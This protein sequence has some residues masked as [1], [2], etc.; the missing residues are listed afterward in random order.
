MRVYLGS[1]HA[2]FELKNHLVNHL[3]KQGHDVVDVGP[4]VYDPEDDYPAFCLH[5]GA[6]V[7]A[8]PGSLGVVIGGSGNG[9]QIAA[10]KIAGVRVGA[11]LEGRDRRSWPAST[12][13]PTCCGI[14]ARQHTLDEATA[15][16]EA[17]L[18]T[19]FSGNPRHARRIAQ[20]AE[21]ERTRELPP[22][23]ASLIPLSGCGAGPRGAASCAARWS[24][25][26]RRR[27]AAPSVGPG[28]VPGAQ[29][30]PDADLRRAGADQAA[31]PALGLAVVTARARAGGGPGPRRRGVGRGV[32]RRIGSTRLRSAA[33][34]AAVGAGHRRRSAA[35]RRPAG[36]R[37]GRRGRRRGSRRGTQPAASTFGF[38]HAAEPTAAGRT[39]EHLGG[40]RHPVPAER[41]RRRGAA[42]PGSAPGPGRP[43][44]SA[45][46][47]VPPRY[48]RAQL[49]HGAGE[50]GRVVG[51]RAGRAVRAAGEP[52]AAGVLRQQRVGHLEDHVDGRGV[53]PGGQRLSAGR[54]SGP[55][56]RPAPGRRAGAA[57]PPGAAAARRAPAKPAVAVRAR[58]MVSRKRHSAAYAAGSVGHHLADLD[59]ASGP[60]RVPAA[61]GA[62]QRVPGRA[63]RGV[64]ARRRAA[65]CRRSRCAGRSESTNRH[66]RSSRLD[67]PVRSARNCS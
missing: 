7:V 23:P 3:Q 2:G 54:R 17:F 63:V 50:V 44:P 1:D 26:P 21:Y 37:G 49:Q 60:V 51:A 12:T 15:F 52:P 46:S 36:R 67:Q 6:K 20:L 30:R 64:V 9:E 55:T 29:R 38:A 24:G 47:E 56:A 41:G 4:H 62:P 53:P 45:A 65:R 25:S 66:Q 19:P 34:V 39:S 33:A 18:A 61:L 48:D 16:V 27:R 32:V 31:Q 40:I 43:R 11:G 57:R 5:T 28:G 42:R 13:T 35:G 58:S 8:D 22:L 14:G 10:N 59:L